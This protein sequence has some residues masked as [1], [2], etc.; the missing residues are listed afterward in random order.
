M[1]E[2]KF[3]INSFDV[4]P[5]G[6]VKPS[7]VMKYMQQAARE[8]CDGEGCTYVFMREKN[9]VFVL[10]KLGLEFYRPIKIGE[11]LTVKTFN[12]SIDGVTFDR[13]Y[14][15]FVENEKVAYAST[16][17]VL[18]RFDDRTIVRPKQFEFAFYSHRL[19]CDHVEVPRRFDTESLDKIGQRKVRVSDLVLAY[20]LNGERFCLPHEKGAPVIRLHIRVQHLDALVY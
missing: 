4:Y 15:F 11:V 20:P 8:D 13:E 9:I 1:I 14:E 3:T 17:W 16:F 5:S 19:E 18:V 6:E 12:N 7:A 10:I 2:R